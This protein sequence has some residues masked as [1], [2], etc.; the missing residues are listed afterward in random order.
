MVQWP[1][2]PSANGRERGAK[3]PSRHSPFAALATHPALTEP[4]R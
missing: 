2:R 1:D 4:G 3:P